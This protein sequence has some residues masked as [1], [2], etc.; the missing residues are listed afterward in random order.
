MI[1]VIRWLLGDE[2]SRAMQAELAAID[3]H[4]ARRRFLLGCLVASLARA[5]TWLR[6]GSVALVGSVPA[7]LFTGPGNGGEL[8]GVAIVA[9]ML[10]I[11]LVAIACLDDLSLAARLAGAGGLV[12]W[13]GV[14]TSES[15][16]S[17]P[18][19]ALAVLAVT[20]GV[21]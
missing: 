12:W 3:D 11:A 2:W 15:V 4:R 6:I 10:A 8:V 1:R 19:W 18:Q 17:H 14:L 13:A 5:T 7:L 20:G 9:V 21:A 16:R